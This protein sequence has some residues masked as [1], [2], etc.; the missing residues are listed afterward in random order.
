MNDN[1][2]MANKLSAFLST[3]SHTLSSL[4]ADYNKYLEVQKAS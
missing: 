3:I 2:F 4:A 1:D